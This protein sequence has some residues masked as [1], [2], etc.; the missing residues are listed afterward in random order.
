M[1]RAGAVFSDLIE[2]SPLSWAVATSSRVNAGV[3]LDNDDHNF[4]L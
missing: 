2:K 1:S 3:I 4:K